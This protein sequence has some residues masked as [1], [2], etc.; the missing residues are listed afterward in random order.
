MSRPNFQPNEVV[1][2]GS[3]TQLQVCGN[4]NKIAWQG[5]C[6]YILL[7]MTLQ[8]LNISIVIVVFLCC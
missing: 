2:Q 5:K 7:E 4:L 1:G 8:C 3:E 6:Q